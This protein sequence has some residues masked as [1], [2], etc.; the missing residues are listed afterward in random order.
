MTPLRAQ[1]IAHRAGIGFG[2]VDGTRHRHYWAFAGWHRGHAV[3]DVVNIPYAA[4]AK[5]RTEA[6]LLALLPG[7]HT[8]PLSPPMEPAP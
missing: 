4:I 3:S 6:D 2:P 7:P 5:A 8:T 1:E